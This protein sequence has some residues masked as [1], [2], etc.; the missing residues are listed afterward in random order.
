MMQYM[1][2]SMCDETDYWLVLVPDIRSVR[3]R[4]PFIG[5]VP[6]LKSQKPPRREDKEHS[7]FSCHP[8]NPLS[9]T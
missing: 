1:D 2:S 3:F 9:R 4:Q 5:A 8:T 6:V 7:H